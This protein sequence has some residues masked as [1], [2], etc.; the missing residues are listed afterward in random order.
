MLAL[1]QLLNG[2]TDKSAATLESCLIDNPNATDVVVLLAHV[3]LIQGRV[4]DAYALYRQFYSG[5]DSFGEAF[6]DNVALFEEVLGVDRSNFKLIY[7]A[8]C[9]GALDD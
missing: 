6:W 2:E 4:A 8:V 9:L 5:N 1:A 7:D 3:R